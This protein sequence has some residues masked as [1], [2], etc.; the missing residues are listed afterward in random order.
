MA[1]EVPAPGHESSGSPPQPRRLTSE[2]DH[3]DNQFDLRPS[4]GMIF[5]VLL[6]LPFWT[7]AVC[8]AWLILG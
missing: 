8:L 3:E 7:V 5:G 4:I 6:S 1:D 2:I